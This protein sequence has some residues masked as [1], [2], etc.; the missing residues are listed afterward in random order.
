MLSSQNQTI[1]KHF[2]FLPSSWLLWATSRVHSSHHATNSAGKWDGR[3]FSKKKQTGG[4]FSEISERDF[5]HICGWM[6]ETEVI[7][8]LGAFREACS[9]A[10]ELT[11]LV[12]GPRVTKQSRRQMRWTF[13][14]GTQELAGLP[15]FLTVSF[16]DTTEESIS[17][18]IRPR[19]RKEM[20]SIKPWVFF[21]S[22]SRHGVVGCSQL[23]PQDDILR[24]SK[25][26]GKFSINN[27]FFSRSRRA[28]KGNQY[29]LPLLLAK[30]TTLVIWVW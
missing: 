26:E 9:L 25:R 6:T 28:Q 16:Y 20:S 18:A 5:Q 1:I 19:T 30:R 27:L 2:F 7:L 22:S 13:F 21:F 4:F 23:I 14:A 29:S 12:M 15:P 8:T 11:W 3:K 10:S 17:T 24:H